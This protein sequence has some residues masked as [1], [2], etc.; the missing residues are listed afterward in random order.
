[1]LA[2][3]RDIIRTLSFALVLLLATVLVPQALASTG[4]ESGKRVALVVGNQDYVAAERLKNALNDSRA[5]SR[6]LS[7]LGFE[8]YEAENL[9]RGNFQEAL[10]DLER[11]AEGAS[12]VVFY[13]S[14]HGFQLGGTNY[15]VPTDAS[16][17]SRDAIASETMRL[18]DIVA[19]IQARN[20][21]T[22]I[23]L[24]ACRNNPLP[25]SVRGSAGDGLAQMETGS[26]TF[27]AF[28]TQPGNITRDGGGDNSPF[29][30]AL[31]EHIHTPGI[32][33]SD[34][35]IRVR[36][37]VEEATLQT[38]TPWDQSSLRSQFYF[39]PEDEADPTLTDEDR[40][41]L[42]SLDPAL[43][44]KFEQRFNIRI[45]GTADSAA[46][47]E[48]QKLVASIQPR[49]R[50][51]GGAEEPADAPDQRAVPVEAAPQREPDG[52][53]D[54]ATQVART[55]P[56]VPVTR[57]LIVP[58]AGEQAEAEPDGFAALPPGLAPDVPVPGFRP[59]EAEPVSQ[60]AS[61][62]R[63]DPIEATRPTDALIAQPGSADR[64]TGTGESERAA[65]ARDSERLAPSATP[66]RPEEAGDIEVA[67]VS[68]VE[69]LSPRVAGSLAESHG[70]SP[71]S[72][73][74]LTPS[75]GLALQPVRG[76]HDRIV[77]TEVVE[78][79]EVEVAA[80][81]PAQTRP[82]PITR[83]EAVEEPEEPETVVPAEPEYDEREMAALIQT[84]LARLGCYRSSV[85][86]I[87]GNLS[88]RGL[89]RYF[90]TKQIE[91]DNLEPSPAL[92]ARL[93]AEDQVVCT[94]TETAPA[95]PQQQ[96]RRTVR[97][98]PPAPQRPAAAQQQRPAQV[99]RQQQRP[100]AQAQRP[101]A[102]AQRPA[103]AAEEPRISRRLR[104][105]GMR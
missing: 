16:L 104:I 93:S 31:V 79:R 20:R 66:E 83:P 52:P 78:E 63:A 53:E 17:S 70:G 57:L 1:M 38:Q 92:L 94:R 62:D 55:E 41:L 81:D 85:D 74:T 37:S 46:E 61:L 73:P 60:V 24:D 91:P 69:S 95:A 43:R 28:A 12:A 72:R 76:E 98:Q 5:I 68:P 15:L 8:V 33:I 9:T 103:A 71:S 25:A 40:E 101:A 27:V 100:T 58:S 59:G 51:S 48:P 82:E 49:F 39:N 102:Q 89:L 44:E 87:W 2:G 75:S 77:G 45:V 6:A 88:A 35:M 99:Q 90:A 26:G 10:D 30:S 7:D 32:S 3:Q 65:S 29:T 4:G 86:G 18:D 105:G 50:I 64:A 36:N 21:Q 47:P 19:R 56:A 84:E 67:A 54:Q 34:M 14:G 97:Q 96:Q 80:L 42:M 22:L 11:A 23:F 13:F